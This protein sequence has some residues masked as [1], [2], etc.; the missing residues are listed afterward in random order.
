[1]SITEATLLTRVKK[2]TR[3]DELA[4][5]GDNSNADF[6]YYMNL[7]VRRLSQDSLSLRGTDT[8]SVTAG[9]DTITLP[10][11]CIDGIAAI[12]NLSLGTTNENRFNPEQDYISWEEY[13]AGA[14]RGFALRNKTL[15]LNPKQETDRNYTFDYRKFHGTTISTLEFEDKYEECI[16]S[17]LCHYVY[18]DLELQDKADTMEVEYKRKL[19]EVVDDD[20]PPIVKS[21]QRS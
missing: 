16:V 12:D 13:R 10:S 18:D 5:L 8:G 14:K 7:M 2:R 3:R 19:S 20:Q 17:L 4:V 21:R 15:Y 1:M 11:D 9:T 6:S